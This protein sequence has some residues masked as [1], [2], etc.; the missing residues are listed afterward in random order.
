[1]ELIHPLSVPSPPTGITNEY[2]CIASSPS[3]ESLEPEGPL[4]TVRAANVASSA[5]SVTNTFFSPT[6]SDAIDIK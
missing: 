5:V 3:G 4:T 6:I 1:M 2:L